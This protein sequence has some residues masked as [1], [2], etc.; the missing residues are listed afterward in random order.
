MD[1]VDTAGAPS[2]GATMHYYL[3]VDIGASTVKLGLINGAGE[4]LGT[5]HDFDSKAHEGPGGTMKMIARGIPELLEETGLTDAT[6]AAVGACSPT[7]V[8]ADGACVYPTNIDASWEGVNVKRL[9]SETVAAPAYLL[10]DGDAAAYR[11]YAVRAAQGRA[12]RGMVQFIT[13]TGLGGSIII[14]GEVF[15]G[16]G[17]T[18]ELGHVITDTSDAADRCGCGAV[19]CA[20]TRASLTGLAN[21]VRRRAEAGTLPPELDGEPARVARSLRGLGQV[22]S[23]LPVVQEIWEEYFTH[24]GRAARTVANTVGCDLIVVSGGGQERERDASESAWKRFLQAGLNTVRRELRESFPHLEQI[25]VEWAINQLPDSAAYGAAA[26]A[27][28]AT[29]GATG[30]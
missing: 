1:R 18:A 16:P 3:G 22:E 9:L 26:Y 21:I 14:N 15:A 6:I 7:P 4:I 13:G 10:N 19:G 30:V 12:S 2:Y 29:E 23:P 24:L 27:A 8:N 28:H 11:E 20:E 17:V 5:R 25:R